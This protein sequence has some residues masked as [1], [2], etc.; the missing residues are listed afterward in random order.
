MLWHTSFESVQQR[1]QAAI[2]DGQES[3]Q[4][5]RLE[6]GQSHTALDWLWAVHA[7]QT[8]LETRVDGT[9]PEITFGGE[10]AL[11][12][13]LFLKS[14]ATADAPQ[15]LEPAF[16]FT[17][18]ERTVQM[19]VGRTLLASVTPHVAPALEP[20]QHAGW[21]A[22]PFVMQPVVRLQPF[23]HSPTGAT[24]TIAWAALLLAVALILAPLFG[25]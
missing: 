4:A 22:L 15:V 13:Y 10:S 25:R 18:V 14:R 20:G 19:A 6:L 11:W 5:P 23:S 16:I 3:G 9:A 21:E 2:T 7:L 12:L 1:W 17:G 24:R 8:W